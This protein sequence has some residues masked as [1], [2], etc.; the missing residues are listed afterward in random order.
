[1]EG[2]RKGSRGCS[3]KGM[4][5]WRPGGDGTI[6]TDA[7]TADAARSLV[8]RRVPGP[9]ETLREVIRTD[10]AEVSTLGNKHASIAGH[11]ENGTDQGVPA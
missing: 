11:L 4:A 6:D 1:M 3:R 2:P 10:E 7:R 8:R 5:C 9:T